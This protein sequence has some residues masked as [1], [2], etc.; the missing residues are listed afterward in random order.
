M[1]VPWLKTLE[2]STPRGCQCPMQTIRHC[3]RSGWWCLRHWCPTALSRWAY[4]RWAKTYRCK[5]PGWQ[6]SRSTPDRW[7]MRPGCSPASC[8]WL[9]LQ[10]TSPRPSWPSTRF[11]YWS[12]PYLLYWALRCHCWCCLPLW[13]KKK[14]WPSGRLPC[15]CPQGRL[16]RCWRVTGCWFVRWPGHRLRWLW[17]KPWMQ[18]RRWYWYW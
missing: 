14:F 7:L 6:E 5:R 18:S 9:S 4:C 13:H 10:K 8:C 11:E 16:W 12:G 3:Q 1:R 17:N 15:R 2:T